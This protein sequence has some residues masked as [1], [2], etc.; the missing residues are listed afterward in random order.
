MVVVSPLKTYIIMHL[1]FKNAKTTH[2]LNEISSKN[3]KYLNG[4][5][6]KIYINII[7]HKKIHP[8]IPFTTIVLKYICNFF[9][10]CDKYY[11]VTNILHTFKI[12][13]V[14][15]IFKKYIR[16]SFKLIKYTFK[17]KNKNPRCDVK[18]I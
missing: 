16:L 7:Q 17:K 12:F 14:C 13:I 2:F 5:R 9:K 1:L 18:K 6:F 11:F 15:W 8:R 10:F 4:P 3:F